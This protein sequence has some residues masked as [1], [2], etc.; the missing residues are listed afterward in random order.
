MREGEGWE[1]G[2]YESSCCHSIAH[3][4]GDDKEDQHA[5]SWEGSGEELT[6]HQNPRWSQ[7]DRT[8]KRQ[9]REGQREGMGRTASKPAIAPD[10]PT[11]GPLPSISFREASDASPPPTADRR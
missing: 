2:A 4:N 1:G 10:A 7:P 8:C 11:D 9:R 3:L 5:L 6:P